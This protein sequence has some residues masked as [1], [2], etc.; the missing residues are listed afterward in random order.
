MKLSIL[1]SNLTVPRV[2]IRESGD[3]ALNKTDLFWSTTSGELKRSLIL[4]TVL[5]E[6]K[7]ISAPESTREDTGQEPTITSINTLSEMLLDPILY[8]KG[9]ST[10][11]HASSDTSDDSMAT[12]PCKTAASNGLN[13]FLQFDPSRPLTRD[14]QGEDALLDNKTYTGE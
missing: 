2:F 4:S 3:K 9:L 11:V 6:I 5:A 13:S 7:L 8:T 12:G 1:T 10:W 14:N